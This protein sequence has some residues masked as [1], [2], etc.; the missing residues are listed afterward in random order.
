MFVNG[1]VHDISEQEYHEL[2]QV[3]NS[4]LSKFAVSP[5]L[6]HAHKNGM[7]PAEEKEA[8]E[9]GTAFDLMVFDPKRFRREYIVMD[10]DVVKPVREQQ[11]KFVEALSQGATPVE[12]YDAAYSTP[13]E[14]KAEALGEKLGP[15][16]A[17]LDK[18][19]QGFR[20]LS[21]EDNGKLEAMLSSL[22]NHQA[23]WDMIQENRTQVAIT[24]EYEGLGTR[25][26]LDVM[27]PL[28]IGD[29]KTTGNPI[30]QYRKSFYRFGYAR[31][32]AMYRELCYAAELFEDVPYLY[33]IVVEKQGRFECKVFDVHRHME[34]AIDWLK[35]L[36]DGVLWH[37]EKNVWDHSR[38]YYENAGVEVLV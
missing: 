4:D 31:Q 12:A 10:D 18:K 29:L 20:L 33:H 22:E 25:G 13:D 2:G 1:V 23:A 19:R 30:H 38:E 14:K 6:Y 24:A 11:H 16:A 3:S 32:F 37:T 28:F 21:S 27:G 35:N 9:F 34:G 15:Y 26:L 5:S 8:W 36:L 17:L 7:L